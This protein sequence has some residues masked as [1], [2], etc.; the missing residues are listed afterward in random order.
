MLCASKLTVPVRDVFDASGRPTVADA[1]FHSS[2]LLSS[3]NDPRLT[4]HSCH[5]V[6]A[7][8]ALTK[9]LAI[10]DCSVNPPAT[11]I[12]QLTDGSPVTSTGLVTF[13]LH[14]LRLIGIEPSQNS[15]HSFRIC[16]ATYVSISGLS[17]YGIELIGRGNSDC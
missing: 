13:G 2:S 3:S 12:F 7:V 5:L 16:C 15:G 6:C 8:S 1:Q 10:R 17:D 11:L 14:L 9:T 4:K